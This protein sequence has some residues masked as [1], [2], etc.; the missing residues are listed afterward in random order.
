MKVSSFKDLEIWKLGR[1]IRN[2][3]YHITKG[4]PKSETYNLVPQMRRAAISVTANIAE[5]YGRYH[6][7]E[8]IQFL[9]MARGSL[10]ELLDHITTC[11][12]LGYISDE[13]NTELN[14]L[15]YLNI[16]KVNGYISYLEKRKH[17]EK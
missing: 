5:G 16:K 12:D 10:Y 13:I 7:Q 14:N 8:N 2:R 11:N 17:G 6:F 4:M 1:E 9:R 3:I 15:L